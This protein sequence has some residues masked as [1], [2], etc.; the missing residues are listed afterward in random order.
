[1]PCPLVSLR[2]SEAKSCAERATSRPSSRA[3]ANSTTSSMNE[4]AL[5]HTQARLSKKRVVGCHKDF[6]YARGLHKVQISGNLNQQSFMRQD[7]F[8]LCAPTYQA[9][10][11]LT[12]LPRAHQRANGVN[13][14]RK[15]QA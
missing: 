7:I 5:A 1:M 12:W 4:H 2:I 11:T 13:F 9:H 15:F 14:A 8:S 6:W 10:H 3:R